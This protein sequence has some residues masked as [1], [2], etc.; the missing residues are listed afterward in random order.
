M[1]TSLNSAYAHETV[2]ACK[3]R[4]V[5]LGCREPLV[6]ASD[7]RAT[8]HSVVIVQ[9]MIERGWRITANFLPRGAWG[10]AQSAEWFILLVKAGAIHSTFV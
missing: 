7:F 8:N 6:A 9:T 4:L 2:T 10:V 3:K 1:V 5:P